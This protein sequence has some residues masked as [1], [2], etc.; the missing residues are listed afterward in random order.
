MGM[1]HGW[2]FAVWAQREPNTEAK[3]R[4]CARVWA[5]ECTIGTRSWRDEKKTKKTNMTTGLRPQR[6]EA[7]LGTVGLE[8]AAQQQAPPLPGVD[9]STRTKRRAR[10]ASAHG[11]RTQRTEPVLAVARRLAFTLRPTLC[12]RMEQ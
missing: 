4:V 11:T 2:P 12:A 10:P 8:G 9:T 6:T 1:R 5:R 3:A 7:A